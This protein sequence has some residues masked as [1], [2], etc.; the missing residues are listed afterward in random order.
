MTETVN[1]LINVFFF[2][3]LTAEYSRCNGEVFEIYVVLNI[4]N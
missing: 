3:L 2:Y 1:L 4:L